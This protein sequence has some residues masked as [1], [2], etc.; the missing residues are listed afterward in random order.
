MGTPA[1]LYDLGGDQ[2]QQQQP[3]QQQQGPS[4][5]QAQPGPVKQGLRGF[6][7]QMMH[8]MAAGGLPGAAYPGDLIGEAHD[9]R[10]AA[11]A[12]TNARAALT[13]AQADVMKNTVPFTLPN[14]AM[15]HLPAAMATKLLQQ[16]LANQGKVE[17]NKVNKR[18]L[19]TPQ[20]LYDTQTPDANGFPTLIPNSGSG[21]SITPDIAQQYGLP[22]EYVGKNMKLTDLASIERGGAAQNA[23]QQTASGPVVVPKSGPNMGK[24]TPVTVDG[25]PIMSNQQAGAYWQAKYGV[26]QTVDPDGNPIFARRLDA[27]GA[28]TNTGALSIFKGR[29]GLDNYKDALGRVQQNLDVLDDPKQRALIAQTM[30]GIGTVHDPGIISAAIGNAVSS[31]LDPRA[32]DLTAAM[33][34]AREFIGANRQFAGNFNGSEALYNRMVANAPG[35]A[36]SKELNTA[37]INQ[38]LANTAR[39]EARM[40]QFQGGNRGGKTQAPQA[41]ASSSS[42]FNWGSAPVKR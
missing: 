32:A 36:N 25:K 12:E 28:P 21:I 26:V 16:Q 9:Q 20:G 1:Q 39:I 11:I 18:F 2:Q 38:D 31:G 41:P 42:G 23:V 33:L 35:A 4:T 40:K 6:L 5:Q 7:M 19:T 14:G 30:R 27:P 3:Q 29:A 37:L 8:N 10:Q 22:P 34:Q 24:A 15:V 17:A 13:Q